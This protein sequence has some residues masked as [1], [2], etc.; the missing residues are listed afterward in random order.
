MGSA[1]ERGQCVK[2]QQQ[3]QQQQRQSRRQ[4]RM[5]LR[6]PLS[7]RCRPSLSLSSSPSLSWPPAGRG[8]NFRP[9]DLAVGLVQGRRR[10][11]LRFVFGW[12][13]MRRDEGGGPSDSAGCRREWCEA[14]ARRDFGMAPLLKAVNTR[15]AVG[16]FG[17]GSGSAWSPRSR[18]PIGLSSGGPCHALRQK[19]VVV[20]SEHLQKKSLPRKTQHFPFNINK[21]H[22]QP[23]S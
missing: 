11:L 10:A 17:S 4:Q 12:P 13:A 22:Q 5:L 1:D 15:A 14:P 8:S 7:R 18:R 20:L 3:E 23:T 21:Q 2:Q 9:H 16:H 19:K 6:R